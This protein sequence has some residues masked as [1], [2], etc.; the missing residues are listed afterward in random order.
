MNIVTE[1]CKFEQDWQARL[2]RPKQERD[3]MRKRKGEREER[4][5]WGRCFIWLKNHCLYLTRSCSQREHNIIMDS[6]LPSL[7]YTYLT[8]VVKLTHQNFFWLL[9]LSAYFQKL[10]FTMR[11]F[12]IEV[13]AREQWKVFLHSKQYVLIKRLICSQQSCLRQCLKSW[14]GIVVFFSTAAT[15]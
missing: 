8:I 13:Q 4:E 9:R 15:E 2:A 3:E 11:N 10:K 6:N 14:K 12:F 5:R 7:N 1:E